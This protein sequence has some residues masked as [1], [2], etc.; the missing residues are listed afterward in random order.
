MRTAEL[1]WVVLT[2]AA[3]SC[4]FSTVGV[5][6]DGTVD[7]KGYRT[8]DGDASKLLQGNSGEGVHQGGKKPEWRVEM[9]SLHAGGKSGF[10][11]EGKQGANVAGSQHGSPLLTFT[12]T[13]N[14]PPITWSPWSHLA[15]PYREATLRADSNIGDPSKDTFTWSFPNEG[16]LVYEGR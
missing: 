7:Q 14:Y 2:G 8:V 10:N 1:V 9:D 3:Y 16:G 12:S 13:N 6:A 15:E 5:L 4:S 11:V